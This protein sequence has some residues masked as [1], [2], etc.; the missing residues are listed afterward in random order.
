MKGL[1]ATFRLKRVDKEIAEMLRE[2]AEVKKIV[3][4]TKLPYKVV[5]KKIEKLRK[6]GIVS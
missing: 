2:G 3:R 6:I 5:V 4:R 1:S